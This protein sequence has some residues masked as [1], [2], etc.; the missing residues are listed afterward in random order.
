M[1]D[2]VIIRQSD[3]ASYQYCA[4]QVKL[5]KAAKADGWQEPVLSATARGTVL[6]YAFEVLQK[7]HHEGRADALDVA[8]ATFEH[9]WEPAHIGEISEGPVTEWIGHDTWGGLLQRSLGNLRAAYEWIKKDKSVLLGLEHTFDVPIVIDGEQH[10]LHGTIDRLAL[11]MINSRP[12]I[13]VDDLKGYRRK[14]THLDW[15]TQWTLYSYASLQPQFW[16]PFYVDDAIAEGF[17][18]IVDRLDRRGLAIY[19]ASADDSREVLPRAGRLLWAWDGF[20]AVSTG[21]RT[22]AHYARLRAHLREY[23]K[24]VRA[25]IYPLTVDGH[26]CSYCPFGNGICGDAPLPARQEGIE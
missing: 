25:D 7:L 4:Q 22:E 24:S 9:Y 21:Y 23:I 12:V 2:E 6:H 1:G 26:V 5:K 11:R 10:T 13:G 18:E 3:L 19:A 14:K 8:L 20:Q 16:E 15:A 17:A